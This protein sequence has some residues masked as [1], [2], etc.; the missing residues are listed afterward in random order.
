MPALNLGN[1][2]SIQWK[3]FDTLVNVLLSF[4][5]MPFTAATITI[6]MLPAINAYSIAVAPD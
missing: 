4:K 2:A 5:P 1:T 3:P 6:E